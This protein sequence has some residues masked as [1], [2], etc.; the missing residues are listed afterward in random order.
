MKIILRGVAVG[1]AFLVL[2][3]CASGPGEDVSARPDFAGD[4]PAADF[5]AVPERGYEDMDSVLFGWKNSVLEPLAEKDGGYAEVLRSR[6]E[7]S[8]A[9]L[10]ARDQELRKASPA[11]AA[12]ARISLSAQIAFRKAQLEA[13][14]EALSR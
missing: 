5:F 7:A 9:E 4:R 3:G 11:I 6:I 1:G 8:L 2:T 10:S 14:D 12:E 13:I